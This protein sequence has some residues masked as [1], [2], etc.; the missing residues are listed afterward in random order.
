MDAVKLLADGLA[1]V[2]HEARHVRHLV[3][4]GHLSATG[5]ERLLR[6]PTNRVEVWQAVQAVRADAARRQIAAEATGCFERRFAKSLADLENLYANDHSRHARAVGGHAWRRVTAAVVVLRDAIEHDDGKEIASA[7][8]ALVRVRHNNGNVR[9][10]IT[11]LDAEVGTQTGLWWHDVKR[12]L[13]VCRG[14]TC[15]SPMAEAIGRRTLGSTFC[16]QSAGIEAS[17][18]DPAARH[19]IDV[20]EEKGLNIRGHTARGIDKI[21][22]SAFDAIVAMDPTIAESLRSLGSR[23]QPQEAGHCGSGLR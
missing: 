8:H 16:V 22:V 23:D 6:L 1:L 18:G 2:Y 19:A 3:K 14:N 15:R 11:G 5:W 7:A 17:D 10:K 21:D 20:M 12:V 4:A 13:F 9:D